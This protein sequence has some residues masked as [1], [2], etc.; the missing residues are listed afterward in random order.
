M[1]MI[2]NVFKISLLIVLLL[3]IFNEVRQGYHDFVSILN[4]LDYAKFEQLKIT[5]Y[6]TTNIKKRIEMSE[7]IREVCVKYNWENVDDDEIY[8][9]CRDV[10]GSDI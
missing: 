10:V 3:I 9:F 1:E 6:N 7:L 8:Y 2:K 5:Y 4:S